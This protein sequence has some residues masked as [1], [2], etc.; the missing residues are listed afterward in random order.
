MLKSWHPIFWHNPF[1]HNSVTTKLMWS[2]TVLIMPTLLSISD[3][4]S[5]EWDQ[6]I[7]LRYLTDQWIMTYSS[8]AGFKEHTQSTELTA[9]Y[10]EY[11]FLSQLHD[12]LS[13]WC[14]TLFIHYFC[15]IV[16]L[17]III[18]GNKN[19]VPWFYWHSTDRVLEIII[20]PVCKWA[21]V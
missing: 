18:I 6:N 3:K 16:L 17:N 7:W 11:T 13:L 5:C 14:Y 9:C 4:F 1:P 2:Q 10:N 8:G 19:F 15:S 12:H 21:Y 20:M